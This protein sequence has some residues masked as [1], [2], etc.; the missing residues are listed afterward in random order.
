MAKTDEDDGQPAALFPLKESNERQAVSILLACVERVP[1]LAKTLLE[2]Q[3]VKIG[4]K[5]TVHARTE[6]GPYGSE[7]AERPDGKLVVIT[8][9]GEQPWTA[10]LEAKIGNGKL[11]QDQIEKYLEYA[12]GKK[13]QALITISNHFAIL[14]T[15]HPTYRSRP[16]R[17]RKPLREVSLLHWSWGAVLT[18]CQLLID[19]EKIKDDHRWV[20]EHL[21]QFLR[22][23]KG[24]KWFDT[25]P[26]SWKEITSCIK[27]DLQIDPNM[28]STRQV[29]CAWIQGC[30]ALSLRLSEELKLHVP[31]VFKNKNEQEKPEE[32]IQRVINTLCTSACLEVEY[33]IPDSTY[34]ICVK[35]DLRGPK[36]IT[37]LKVNAP[38][39]PPTTYG[40]VSKLLERLEGSSAAGI[41]VT[42]DYGYNVDMQMEFDVLDKKSKEFYKKALN[43]KDKKMKNE[44][45]S[46]SFEV[47]LVTD[48]NI[49]EQKFI[50]A[51]DSCVLE[52]YKQIGKHLRKWPNSPRPSTVK[53]SRDE[54]TEALQAENKGIQ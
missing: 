22:N 12:K 40:K 4:S 11:E 10:L 8:G 2:G 7:G 48:I 36:L 14:P 1:E 24:I 30:R 23:D 44:R 32:F 5:T 42:A 9:R 35:V 38:H 13:V 51:I 54:S 37:S 25:M 33:A 29:A 21:I 50:P 19:A 46:K 41:S 31:I 39:D 20:V 47:K 27:K 3:G 18:K 17:G 16:K 45:K 34:P 6:V 26:K 49:G 43:E 15:H 52:F 53:R 28:E